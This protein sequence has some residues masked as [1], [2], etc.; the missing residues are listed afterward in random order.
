M[1][2]DAYHETV[3]VFWIK[4]VRHLLDV[5]NKSHSLVELANSAAADCND[6]R[7]IDVYFSAERFASEE[8]RKTWLEPD[9]M[10]LEC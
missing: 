8:A 4:R 7:L 2:P 5:A 9:L 10:P 3:T 6:A 1:S